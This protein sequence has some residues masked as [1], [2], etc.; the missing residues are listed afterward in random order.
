MPEPDHVTLEMLYEAYLSLI[1]QGFR[2]DKDFH[3][4]MGPAPDYRSW[5]L[6]GR[7][8]PERARLLWGLWKEYVL[9]PVL[10]PDVHN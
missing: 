2:H 7:D 9:E 3:L 6:T 5:R 1:E 10:S 8:T 4:L